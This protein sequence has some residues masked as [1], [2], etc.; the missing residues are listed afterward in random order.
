MVECCGLLLSSG[1]NAVVDTHI[2]ARNVA[3]EP[4]RYFEIDPAVLV[5]A[6]RTAR[7]GGAVIR[8]CYHSHPAGPATPSPHDAAMA[9]P[10]GWLWLIL[11]GDGARIG[12]WRA[13]AQG[14]LHGRFDPVEMGFDD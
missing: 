11:S 2:S 10:N 3:G 14:A 5:A 6:H 13:V 9:E 12:L 7:A 4:A 1:Q 8:G